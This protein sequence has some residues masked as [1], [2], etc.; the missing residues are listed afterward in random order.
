M[1]Y[2]CLKSEILGGVPPEGSGFRERSRAKGRVSALA[3][4]NPSREPSRAWGKSKPLLWLQPQ[5]QVERN[6]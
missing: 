1:I 2:P 3:G 4:V 5:I 6:R